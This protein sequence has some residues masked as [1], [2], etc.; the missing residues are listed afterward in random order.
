MSKFGDIF[1]DEDVF[2]TI[3][4]CAIDLMN[5]LHENGL[6]EPSVAVWQMVRAERAVLPFCHAMMLAFHSA[7]ADFKSEQLF[8]FHGSL[9][10]SNSVHPSSVPELRT[11]S[12]D[13]NGSGRF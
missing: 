1:L 10:G 11:R 8:V 13:N 2:D 7:P 6:H 9:N 4:E 3:C 12:T 5:G